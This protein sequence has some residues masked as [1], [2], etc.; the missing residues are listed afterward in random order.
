[1]GIRPKIIMLVVG[2]LVPL[3]G[4]TGLLSVSLMEDVL[5]EEMEQRGLSMLSALSV[6]CSISL[7]SH[8]IERLDDFLAQFRP[9]HRQAAPDLRGLATERAS[10]RDLLYLTVV[11]PAG[12]VL[13][14]TRETAYGEVRRDRFAHQAMASSKP[15]FERIERPDGQTALAVAMPVQSGLRWGTL[16][17]EFSLTRLE[18]RVG[19]LRWNVLFI[20]GV[21]MLLT[22]LALSIGLSRLVV[23]PVKALSSAAV[24][25]GE[26]DLDQRVQLRGHPDELDTLARVFNSTAAELAVHTRDLERKVRER[27]AEIVDKNEEL[28][29]ANERLSSA[30]KRLE[31][32]ATTDGLTGL[33]NK[34]HLLSRLKFEVLRAK[35]GGHR[36]SMMMLD[37]DK[38]KHYNDSHGH[39]AGDRLLSALAGILK[40]NL[41]SIDLLGRFGGEEFCVAMLDTGRKA[42]AKA[43]DKLRKAVEKNVF[44]GQEQQ[45]GGNL[46]ISIGVAELDPDQDEPDD[47]IER[48]DRALYAAKDAGRNRVEVA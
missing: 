25:L 16:L 44:A 33:A 3:I 10:I 48:A 27:S 26:G 24:L 39:L 12:R 8:E 9:E 37:V 35:R 40:E 4:A 1:M 7:A 32:V 21:L 45:P 36:L 42:A 47:L 28:E 18:T 41:R 30:N 23:R 14:H 2:L 19:Q 34:S 6:P 31:E 38:F 13:A 17:A 11:D 46:T 43:A 29:Q 22:V 20:T 5:I 15:L